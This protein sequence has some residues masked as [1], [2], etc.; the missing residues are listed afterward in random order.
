MHGLKAGERLRARKNSSPRSSCAE[1]LSAVRKAPSLGTPPSRN[2]SLCAGRA[3]K[4]VKGDHRQPQRLATNVGPEHSTLERR[5]SPPRG[6]HPVPAPFSLSLDP[7]SLAL[8]VR[9]IAV[10]VLAQADAVR[11]RLREDGRLAFSKEKVAR[12]VLLTVCILGLDK[13]KQE[14]REAA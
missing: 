9:S 12:S 14:A 3:S 6:D 2:P 1:P 13:L 8:L 11:Q 4:A 5:P 10:E 7:Y